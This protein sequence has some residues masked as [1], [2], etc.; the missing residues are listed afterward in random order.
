MRS[1]S[2][3]FI[4]QLVI[5]LLLVLPVGQ[6]AVAGVL[7]CIG[8][9]GHVDFEDGRE[10]DCGDRFDLGDMLHGLPTVES[11]S[12]Q[13][14]TCGDCL[15]VPILVNPSEARVALTK[16]AP[17]PALVLLPAPLVIAP[18][19]SLD[20]VSFAEPGPASPPELAALRTIVLL[21]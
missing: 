6:H 19:A 2:F 18:L 11:S 10:G 16:L 13:D 12:S 15:D 4:A 8:A 3:S 21:V 17:S 5:G 7:I 9:D 1:R 20:A 14:D